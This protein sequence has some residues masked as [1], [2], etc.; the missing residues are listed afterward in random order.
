MMPR[1]GASGDGWSMK[2]VK[3]PR[4][5]VDVTPQLLADAVSRVLADHG[6]EVVV[7]PDEAAVEDCEVVVTSQKFAPDDSGVIVTIVA[8]G[9][10]VRGVPAGQAGEAEPARVRTL[11]ELLT[12]IRVFIG[13]IPLP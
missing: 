3:G 13:V 2:N 10:A 1:P 11:D 4:I 7:H 6:L 8:G 5:A 12:A 9:R